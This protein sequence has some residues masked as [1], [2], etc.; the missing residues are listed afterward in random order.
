MKRS[1]AVGR[2]NDV[3]EG[4]DRASGW[5]ETTVERAYV[6]ASPLDVEVELDHVSLAFVVN[7]PA[8]SVPWMSRPPH[9]EVLAA[10]VRFPKL[11]LAWHWR[12]A[13]WPVWNHKIDRAVLVWNREGGREEG[14]LLAL[15]SGELDGVTIAAPKTRDE[16][17]AQLRVERDVG[18]RHLASVSESFYDPHWRRAHRTEDVR[19]EDHLWWASAGYLELDDALRRVESGGPVRT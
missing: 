10:R 17:A 8:A 9:L 4:L 15:T 13:E 16:L 3:V 2:L 6:Y 5:P 14:A 12:P 19:P 7:E 18:R 1:T 11:P